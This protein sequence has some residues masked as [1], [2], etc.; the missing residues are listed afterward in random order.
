MTESGIVHAFAKCEDCDW[1]ED[2]YLK[3]VQ[4]LAHEHATKNKHKVSLELGISID[5]SKRNKFLK[6]LGIKESD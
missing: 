6:S 1:Y 2:D 4:R 5:G 3:P